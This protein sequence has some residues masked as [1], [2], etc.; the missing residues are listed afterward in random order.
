MPNVVPHIPFRR[1]DQ[2]KGSVGIAVY[3]MSDASAYHTADCLVVDG[4]YEMAPIF[5]TIG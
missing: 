1:F 4:N 5:W 3:L 2:P